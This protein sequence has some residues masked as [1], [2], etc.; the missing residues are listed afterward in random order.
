MLF[1]SLEVVI[2]TNRISVRNTKS[3]ETD[4]ADAPFSCSHQLI[5][6]VDIFEHA[7]NQLFKQAAGTSW[8]S[9]LLTTVS[10]PG[11]A[12][13]SIEQKVIGD[14]L[15]NAGARQVFFAESVSACEEQLASQLAYVERAK[16]KR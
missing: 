12:L 6:D 10:V 5:Q 11:R 8:W 3:G 1:P 16:R 9:F 14:L 4:S 15:K 7:C 13:H 2:Q